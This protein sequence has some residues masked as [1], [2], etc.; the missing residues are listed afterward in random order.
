[1]LRC[2]A[3]RVCLPGQVLVFHLPGVRVQLADARP[4][5]GGTVELETQEVVA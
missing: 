2:P 5:P 3:W 4:D 1:M